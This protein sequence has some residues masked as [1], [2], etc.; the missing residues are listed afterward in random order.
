MA[1]SELVKE[2]VGAGVEGKPDKVGVRVMEDPMATEVLFA[3]RASAGVVEEDP[4]TLIAR[5]QALGCPLIKTCAEM[6]LGPEEL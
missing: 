4:P 1:L 5:V 6:V 3:E 2:R